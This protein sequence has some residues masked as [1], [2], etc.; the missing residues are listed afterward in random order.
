M[1]SLNAKEGPAINI[2]TNIINIFFRLKVYIQFK[3]LDATKKSILSI[4]SSYL[5][6]V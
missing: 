4:F 1:N 6:N 5:D 3:S 2:A